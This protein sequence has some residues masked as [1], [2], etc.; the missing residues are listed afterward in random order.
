MQASNANILVDN[1]SPF[2]DGDLDSLEEYEH[3]N[4][5]ISSDLQTK[6]SESDKEKQEKQT[7]DLSKEK[8][9][10]DYE[11]DH[12]KENANKCEISNSYDFNLNPEPIDSSPDL[13]TNCGDDNNQDLPND[14]GNQVT[15]AYQNSSNVEGKTK[16]LLWTI[17]IK[18]WGLYLKILLSSFRIYLCDF[19]F[20][21]FRCKCKPKK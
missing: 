10:L 16:D 6:H 19:G 21:F 12:S 3:D 8:K 13:L 9:P 1:A 11:R 2:D 5:L 15:S 17:L 20:Y 14:I 18:F 7:T 4:V